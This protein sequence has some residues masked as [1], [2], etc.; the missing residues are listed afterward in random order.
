MNYKKMISSHKENKADMTVAGVPMPID[1]ASD[2]GVIQVDEDNRV[3]GFQEKPKDPKPIPGKPDQIFGSM[4]IYL[5]NRNVL[6]EELGLD[7]K[8]MLSNHDFGKNIIPQMIKRN[9]RVFVHNFTDPTDQ[10]LYWRDIGTR[11][12]YYQANLDL[13]GPNP[14]INLYEKSWPIRTYHSQYPPV[15]I[16]QNSSG[17]GGVINSLVSGGCVISGAVV[18]NSVLSTNVI[19]KNGAKVN[20]SVLME[21]VTV[22]EGAK[23]KNAIIDKEVH[24]PAGTTI[25]YDHDQDKKRFTL[26]A[27]GIV[28]VPKRTPIAG[29]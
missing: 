8:N 1:T 14:A 25:G 24:I 27:S 4:G 22:G 6:V 28:I 17:E 2:F 20:D 23:I 15:K 9:K 10:P 18:E 29:Q 3:L 16:A 11:D 7:S 26:T 19:V 5:F 21:A 12:A 13:I